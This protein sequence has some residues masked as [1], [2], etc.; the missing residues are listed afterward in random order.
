M[1]IRVK[2]QLNGLNERIKQITEEANKIQVKIK[3]DKRTGT[4][5]ISGHAI[6]VN[7]LLTVNMGLDRQTV[8][9]IITNAW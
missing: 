6:D 4:C 8:D 7:Y 1:S 3:H 2:V 9:E 5:I